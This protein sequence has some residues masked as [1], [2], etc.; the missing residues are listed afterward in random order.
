VPRRFFL[1]TLM[2]VI[3]AQAGICQRE[4]VKDCKTDD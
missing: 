1:T 2:I 3:P 4:A